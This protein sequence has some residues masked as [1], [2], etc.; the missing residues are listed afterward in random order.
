VRRGI[1]H[2]ARSAGGTESPAPTRECDEPLPATVVA[3]D[4]KEASAEKPAVEKGAELALDEAGDDAAL[5]AGGGEKGLEALLHDAVENGGLRRA[6]LV[7]LRIGQ[8]VTD[9][10]VIRHEQELVRVACLR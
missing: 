1:G 2:A 7:L 6:P 4:A 3:T 5:I 10:S 9:E 8:F